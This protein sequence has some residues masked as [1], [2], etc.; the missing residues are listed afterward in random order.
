MPACSH[1]ERITPVA[2]AGPAECT[3]C[4]P[5]GD[6]WVHLR[7]CLSCG[8]VGCCDSSP[9]RHAARHFRATGHPV[10]V[11]HEPEESWGWCFPDRAFLDLTGPAG[12]GEG[13]PR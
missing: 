1:L 4:A 3:E 2:A 9:G 11:S 5:A 7:R 12:S 13:T 8:H 10:V 6:T